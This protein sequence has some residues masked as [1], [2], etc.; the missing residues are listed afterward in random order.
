MSGAGAAACS[1]VACWLGLVG[2]R[3][4]SFRVPGWTAGGQC[5]IGGVLVL[6][7]ESIVARASA[8]FGG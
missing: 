8:S 4:H 3:Y 6:Q 1:G 2:H 5:L 7:P